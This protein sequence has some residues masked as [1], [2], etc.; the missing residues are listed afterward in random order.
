VTVDLLVS[1]SPQRPSDVLAESPATAPAD[2]AAAAGRA[3]T[4]QHG[5]ATSATARAGALK[6]AGDLVAANAGRLEELVVREV[7]KPRLEARGEVARSVAILHYNAQQALDPVGE[8]YP[9]STAGLLYTERRPHGVAGLITPWNFP[10]AIPLWKAAPALAAGNAVLL[11]PSTEALA[12]ARLLEELL[13]QV[14]PADLFAVLPGEGETGAALIEQVDVLSFTGSSAVGRRVAVA[15]TQ[16]GIPVQAE[17]GGQ[18]AAIVLPD[19]DLESTAAMLAGAAMG[20]AGQKCTATR[21]VLVVG[22]ATAFTEAYVAAVSALVPGD[23]A[24]DA[25]MVGPLITRGARDTVLAAGQETRSGG[26]RVLAGGSDPGRDGWFAAPTVVD[27]LSPQ[28]RLAREETFGPFVAVLSVPDVATAVEVSNAV[29]YGLVSSV[30]GQDLEPV[31]RAVAGLDTGLIKVNAPT[32]G[33]DFYAPFGGEKSSSSGPREQGKAGLAFYSSVRTI[34]LAPG[35][36]RPAPAPLPR[37]GP[38]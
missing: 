17:M 16:R 15:A 29:P 6:A 10:L 19:A 38:A 18:N 11:K 5:W 24:D 9:P 35:T 37:K 34:T 36:R 25:T 30:H 32:T 26:G 8:T 23:P 33:V 12:C 13:A 28:A 22:D 27:G 31:L 2:V 21:R 7:G 14:L 20:Y 1:R 3:R 4:A